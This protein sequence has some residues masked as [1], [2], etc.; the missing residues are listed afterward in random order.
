MHPTVFLNIQKK[1]SPAFSS[2]SHLCPCC[3]FKVFSILI[4]VIENKVLGKLYPLNLLFVHFATAF[5]SDFLLGIVFVFWC[6]YI[7]IYTYIQYIL[8]II[9]TM[10]HARVTVGMHS[11]HAM[12]YSPATYSDGLSKDV[13]RFQGDQ[14]LQTSKVVSSQLPLFIL[15]TK[16]FLRNGLQ[17]FYITQ[18]DNT[19]LNFRQ[20]LNEVLWIKH[21][22]WGEERLC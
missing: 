17:S 11:F 16:G 8:Y 21:N 14:L 4:A 12:D 2:L 5:L 13:S 22:E 9:S 20:H 6:V 18:A 19:Y 7:Y 3:L 10:S 1:I 15:P